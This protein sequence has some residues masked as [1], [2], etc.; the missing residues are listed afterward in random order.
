MSCH[1]DAVDA[2]LA[3]FSDHV[4]KGTAR[5]TLDHLDPH[6]RQ[7]AADLMRLME[8]GR[9]IDPSASAPSLEVLLAD[10]EFADSLPPAASSPAP[11]VL[12]QL[13]DVLT[14]VDAPGA[15]SCLH[16]SVRACQLEPR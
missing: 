6:D 2:V 8:T 5:P 15:S 10:T 13:R 12:H 11:P 7:V 4:T 9:R 16:A 3:A 1:S 14:E